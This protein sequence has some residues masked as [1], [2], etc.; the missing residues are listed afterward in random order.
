M[1]EKKR[2]ESIRM[3]NDSIVIMILQIILLPF[4]TGGACIEEMN[5]ELF[6][7]SLLWIYHPVLL[8]KVVQQINHNRTINM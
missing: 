7:Q 8:A 2:G 6:G 5:S 3:M 4:Q 1:S